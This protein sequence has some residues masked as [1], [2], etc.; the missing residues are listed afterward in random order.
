[1]QLWTLIIERI[2]AMLE[3]E[4]PEK[5]SKNLQFEKVNFPKMMVAVPRLAVFEENV[6][7]SMMV[8]TVN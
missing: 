3:A 1:M 5:L 6:Q 8:I 7:F 2:V 4:A